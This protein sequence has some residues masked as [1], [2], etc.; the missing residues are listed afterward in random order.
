MHGQTRREPCIGRQLSMCTFIAVNTHKSR[1]HCPPSTCMHTRPYLYAHIPKSKG[2]T[3]V[4]SFSHTH[5]QVHHTLS[6]ACFAG[7]II[8]CLCACELWSCGWP[9]IGFKWAW[10]LD[11]S[12]KVLRAA[13]ASQ[14]ASGSLPL[15]LTANAKHELMPL[16]NSP[17]KILEI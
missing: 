13:T 8:F 10:L 5:A 15:L 7:Q 9:K 17:G 12:G 3:I 6:W 2:C 1:T 14:L 4:W 11:T 16:S